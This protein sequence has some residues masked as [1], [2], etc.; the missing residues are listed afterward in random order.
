[1]TRKREVV[2]LAGYRTHLIKPDGPRGQAARRTSSSRAG[3][4][5]SALN[6]TGRTRLA[7]LGKEAGEKGFLLIARKAQRSA[8]D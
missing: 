7:A 5:S 1:M 8:A 4:L 3:P 2:K 6:S